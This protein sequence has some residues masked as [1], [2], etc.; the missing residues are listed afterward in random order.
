MPSSVTGGQEPLSSSPPELYRA[1]NRGRIGLTAQNETSTRSFYGTMFALLE[2][3]ERDVD[4]HV[5]LPAD[6]AAAAKLARMS[7]VSTP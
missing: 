1:R 7:R 2:N 6:H 5:L 4:D 3:V